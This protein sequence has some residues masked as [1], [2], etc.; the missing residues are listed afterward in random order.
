LDLAAEEITI[1][2]PSSRRTHVSIVGIGGA[3]NNLLSHAMTRGVDP[4][5]CVAVNTDR[6]QLS[7][8][9]AE[10]KVFLSSD[11]GENQWS[12]TSLGKVELLAHRVTPFTQQSD[13]TI[14]LTGLGGVTGT[15]TAPVI[16]Q[17]HHS[18]LRPVVS[19]VALPFIH[20]RER[21]FVAL[22]G[23]KRMVESC[24]CTVVI[25]NGLQHKTLANVERTADETAA[26]AVRSLSDA[27][28]MSSPLGKQE[29][30]STLA[31]GPVATICMS[32]VAN[33]NDLQLALIEALRTPS[34][35][36]PLSQAKGVIMLYRGGQSL[37]A[38]KVQIAYETICSLVG[39]RVEFRHLNAKSAAPPTLSLF[40]TGYSYGVALG[41]FVDLIQDL[42]NMEYGLD[43]VS[44]GI[45]LPLPLY[46]ME[47]VGKA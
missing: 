8:S 36:L 41:A 26:L 12:R 44:S 20:E 25:D 27:F 35:N 33:M 34:S 47:N 18:R 28:L 2:S 13:F 40:L 1:N 17:L 19:V 30:L 32:P 9:R 31:L 16:A 22:R 43:G 42:Y 14:L 3:G 7:G 5:N 6:N 37:G 46:Q 15:R 38:D 24:D 4:E 23:L 10:N 45:G 11:E 29:I 21:R 39:K